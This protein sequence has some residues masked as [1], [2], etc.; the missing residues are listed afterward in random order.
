MPPLI[1]CCVGLVLAA[2]CPSRQGRS[3]SHWTVSHC[4]CGRMLPV[5]N[6]MLSSLQW[7]ISHRDVT[8][9][10]CVS[11][12][13]AMAGTHCCVAD[14][15]PLYHCAELIT[16]RIPSQV[17][18]RQPLFLFSPGV[19]T[20]SART[21]TDGCDC[22]WKAIETEARHPACGRSQKERPSRQQRASWTSQTVCS[23]EIWA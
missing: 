19:C 4:H 15:V 16:A 5:P 11:I 12:G 3:C 6:G 17:R 2:V 10:E 9:A 8:T 23:P 13:S 1:R 18:L 22:F 14:C 20:R 7:G 21:T